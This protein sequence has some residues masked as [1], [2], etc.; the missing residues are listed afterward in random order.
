MKS[1]AAPSHVA[2]LYSVVLDSESRVNMEKLRGMAAKL[3]FQQVK[4]YIASGNLVYQSDAGIGDQEIMLERAFEK[5]FGKRVDIIVKSRSQW[6]SLLC[7]NPYRELSGEDGS[8][9]FVKIM[10]KPLHLKFLQPVKPLLAM[11][12]RLSCVKGNPWYYVPKSA[13]GSRLHGRISDGKLGV[14]TS[15]NWN[16]VQAI[17]SLLKA[18]GA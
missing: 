15:R 13:Q 9:V 16:T 3:G 17:D 10:R 2:L 8:R 18:E 1:S 11:G 14:G 6:T 4:S 7:D 12:E 5:A